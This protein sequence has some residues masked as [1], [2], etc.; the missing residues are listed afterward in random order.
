MEVVLVIFRSNIFIFLSKISFLNLTIFLKN[1][2]AKNK[3]KVHFKVDLVCFDSDWHSAKILFCDTRV[4]QL[5]N[6]VC[7]LGH[8]I[9][10]FFTNS[11][12]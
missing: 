11:A 1:F 2:F 9:P 6:L 4:S 12:D 10:R 3:K 7:F 5:I 8:G